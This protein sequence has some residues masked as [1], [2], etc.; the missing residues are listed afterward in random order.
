MLRTS[1]TVTTY[2]LHASLLC[3]A[4][5]FT[6]GAGHSWL[7]DFRTWTLVCQ[8]L[9]ADIQYSQKVYTGLLNTKC[10]RITSLTWTRAPSCLTTSKSMQLIVQWIIMFLF[11]QFI[12]H[13]LTNST[14]S[15]K[16]LIVWKI[17]RHGRR[18]K[19]KNQARK[20]IIAQKASMVDQLSI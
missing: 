14:Y 2:L 13:Y 7:P 8:K 10:H 20:A 19:L 1:L 15:P 11:L 5:R 4:A 6:V 18:P 12:T 17:P 16:W 3:P 9:P